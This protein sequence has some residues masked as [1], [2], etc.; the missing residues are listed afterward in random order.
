MQ[1]TKKDKSSR[2]L[3]KMRLVRQLYE[4]GYNED[5]VVNLFKFLDWVLVLPKRLDDEFWR[6]LK[7]Y[8]QER[9]MPYI[10][11]VER[12]GYEGGQKEERRSLIFLLLQQKVGQL[13]DALTD[14]INV[15]SL[16]Q[17]EGLA[18]ALLNFDG[19][20]DLNHWLQANA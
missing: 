9:R 8:E 13:P 7:T 19:T 12:I 18:I 11:S 17:H 15:L 14:R 6:E 1:E 5:Q 4:S 10:T 16:D 2:K 3:W 20:E